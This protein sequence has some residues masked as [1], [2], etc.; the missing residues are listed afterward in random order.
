MSSFGIQGV[1]PESRSMMRPG[2]N[3]TVW[4]AVESTCPCQRAANS[5]RG[6]SISQRGVSWDRD[7]FARMF[8]YFP[9]SNREAIQVP[10]RGRVVLSSLLMY[11]PH[12]RYTVDLDAVSCLGSCTYHHQSY[13]LLG[14][15]YL[16]GGL[17]LMYCS[18]PNEA[19]QEISA[20]N[21]ADHELYY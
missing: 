10:S 18:G 21:S 5:C 9:P 7:T 17:T 20:R 14:H 12:G 16:L 6:K 11:L 2:G 19:F 15:T 13:H 8:A 1:C 4:R 3:C